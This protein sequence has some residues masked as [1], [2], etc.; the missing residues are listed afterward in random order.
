MYLRYLFL[1]YV[2]LP[3]YFSEQTADESELV[4]K[5]EWRKSSLLKPLFMRE[6]LVEKKLVL[7]VKDL[8]HS[9]MSWI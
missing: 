7:Q 4:Y 2:L 5:H 8:L 9:I 1:N 3:F 6:Q